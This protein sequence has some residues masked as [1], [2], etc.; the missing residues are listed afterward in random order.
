MFPISACRHV[1]GGFL[2]SLDH[3]ECLAFDDQGR[4]YAGGEA[5]QI[6]RIT[7]DTIEEYANTGGGVGGIALDGDWNL[8]ECN[9]GTG[10]VNKVEQ[11]GAIT[12]YSSGTPDAPAM[13]PNFP[14]FDSQGNLYYSDSGGWD[15]ANGRIYVVRP[16]GQTELLVPSYLHF[17]NGMALDADERYLYVIQSTVSNVIRFPI[18]D[19]SLGTP[20]IVLTLPTATIPDGLTFA[21]SGNLYVTCFDPDVIYLLRTDGR[22]EVVVQGCNPNILCGPANGAFKDGDDNLYFSNHK[23]WSIASVPVGEYGMPLR[24]P[25]LPPSA[26]EEQNRG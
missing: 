9:Y 14:V 22:L 8:Y 10:L 1:A 4:L 17:P 13:L 11:N 3:P 20:E 21:A 26:P 25:R 12:V 18:E 6:F 2:N 7:G 19:R 23:G 16:E 15:N 24:F 5:G